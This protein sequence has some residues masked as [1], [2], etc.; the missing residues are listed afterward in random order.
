MNLPRSTEILDLHD[1]ALAQADRSTTGDIPQ[2]GDV[3]SCIARNHHCNC[4]LWAEEDQARRR[5]V[6]DA[7]IAANKRAIDGYNQQ[8][9]DA[10]EKI[11]ESLLALL[12][13]EG[14]SGVR[15]NS[16]TAGAMVD[17]LSIL[18]LKVFHM[19]IQTERTDADK[20]HLETSRARLARL[21][22]Q[23]SDLAGCFD[24]LLADCLAGRARFKVYRQF[25][26][27]NDPAFNP[28]LYGAKR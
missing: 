12:P 28:Y 8:R 1:R 22:E 7:A 24:A 18:A 17:R 2:A 14:G 6:P 20:A 26:M 5:D 13:A 4:R 11:D 25:K 9:N 15:L 10:I 16:E 3:W 23:R 19:R 21:S 27:Y